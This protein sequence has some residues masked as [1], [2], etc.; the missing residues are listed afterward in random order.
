MTNS[1]W[2]THLYYQQRWGFVSKSIS[3]KCVKCVVREMSVRQRQNQKTNCFHDT[4]SEGGL[5]V[6]VIK[7]TTKLLLGEVH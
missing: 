5:I 7:I 1:L 4:L 3:L 6:F 2:L